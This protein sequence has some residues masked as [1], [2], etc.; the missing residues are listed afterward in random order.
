MGLLHHA[1][2]RVAHVG[3]M[4]L[5]HLRRALDDRLVGDDRLALAVAHLLQKMGPHDA[6]RGYAGVGAGHLQRSHKH[7]AL[8]DDHIGVVAAAEG[9]LGGHVL[10]ALGLPGR[11]GDDA[12]G[13][14]AQIDVGLLTEAELPQVV[15]ER[16][17][18]YLA[19]AGGP[20]VV[21]S[22]ADLVEDRVAGVHDAPVQIE[23]PMAVV[24]PAALHVP[25][26]EAVP[27]ARAVPRAALRGEA[28]LQ[29]G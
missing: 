23:R 17:L 10:P 21:E 27:F 6:A 28:V 2:Q 18:R 16:R 7:V 15:L 29:A 1:V 4:G 8:A 3:Q 13:L 24:L 25:G 12:H 14:A 9:G 26:A 19:G 20:V 5:G 11:C 22:L